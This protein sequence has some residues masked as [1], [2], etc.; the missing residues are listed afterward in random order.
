MASMIMFTVLRQKRHWVCALIVACFMVATFGSAQTLAPRIK[1]EVISSEQS[2][3][4][5]SLHP[6]AQSRFDA[7][8]LSSET[9]L[10]GITI[11]FNRTDAQESDLKALIAAQ[12]NPASSLYHQWLTPDQY[13]ARFGMSQSDMDK[14]QAWLE[15]QGF[16]LDSV[17][18]SKNS[19]RFSGTVNQVE[20]AFSTQMH[21]YNVGGVKHFAPSTQLSLPVALASTVASVRN[22]NDFKPRPM[23]V[24]NPSVKPRSAYTYNTGSTQYVFFAPPDIKTAYDI[25]ALASSGYTGTG[26]SIA[27]MGQSAIVLS[28]IENFQ[29]ASGLT[30]KDPTVVLVPGTGTSAIV[31]GDE[32]ESDLDLEWSGAIAPGATIYF[33]YTG[34]STNNGVFDSLQYAVDEKIAPI[35]S[36][37]YGACEAEVG[38][39]DITAIEQITSQAA[40]Q[41]QS[42][43]VSSGDQGSTACYGDYGTNSATASDEALAVSYPASSAYVTALGGTKITSANDAVG[44][45][46]TSASSGSVSLSTATQWIPEVVWNDDSASYGASNGWKYALS[47]GGGGVSSYVTRP[48]WQ[49]GTINGVAMPSSNGYRMVPDI[50]LYSSPSYPGYLYCSSDTSSWGTSQKASCGNSEFYDSVTGYFTVAGGT[51]FAAP[52]FAG[53]VAVLNQEKNYVTG[54]GL[55]NP[56]LYSLAANSTTYASAFHDVTSGSIA[57]SAGS[58]YC[59]TAGESGYSATTGY[60]MATGLGSVDLANLAAAWTTSS[61]TLIGTTTSVSASSSSPT[62]GASDTFTITVVAA[63]GS[64]TPSGTITLQIDGGGSSSYGTGTTTT[65]ALSASSTVG[66]ATATY[67]TSFSTAGAHQ[68]VAQFPGSTTFAASAGVASVTVGGTSSGTGNFTLSATN[69]TASQGSTGSSTVTV[70]PANSYTGTVTFTLATSSTSLQSYGCYTVSNATVTGTSSATTTLTFYT[71]SS[72]CS[73]AAVVKGSARHAFVKTGTSAITSSRN[74]SGLPK[75]LPLGAAALA[76]VLL[77]GVRKRRATWLAKLGCFVL[78]GMLSLAVGCGG[79]SSSSSSSSS[80]DV[81]K[82]TYTV[83]LT[84]TDS[85]SSTITSSTTLTLTVD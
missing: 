53:M 28:D 37:S 18:R 6:L 75:A 61:S 46:W 27:I 84:G 62:A 59:S 73:S 45:Y 66:T 77:F 4:E 8:R 79:S 1:A 23:I 12:Q 57:C 41:G 58:T 55:L 15:Q 80:T 85:S 56:T 60:D 21:Y 50:S 13:A 68:I 51:S 29:N 39:T 35:I 30:V 38:K 67:Q 11:V 24:R 9:K 70:K 49:T 83:T 81:A 82:G 33:V 19:I 7:G 74:N 25:K 63:S 78:L 36:I 69:A 44:T 76:G 32:T 14:V 52:V 43:I 42:I 64:T 22:L 10:T 71:S 40:T 20:L 26:Q 65:A 17:A 31:L 3:L 16:S 5:G 34:N 48:S 72:D 47:S 54:Q 2:V